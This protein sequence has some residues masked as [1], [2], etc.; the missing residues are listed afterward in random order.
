[1]VQSLLCRNRFCLKLEFG[2]LNEQTSLVCDVQ[3]DKHS[4]NQ[5]ALHMNCTIYVCTQ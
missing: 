1:M 5:R 2:R 3:C 4:V